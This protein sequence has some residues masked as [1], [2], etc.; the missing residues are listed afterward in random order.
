MGKKHD[1]Y[2]LH[3][4]EML[5]RKLARNA[6]RSTPISDTTK[7]PPAKLRAIRAETKNFLGEPRR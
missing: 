7:Y 1:I 4:T 3:K 6:R 5:R 2:K